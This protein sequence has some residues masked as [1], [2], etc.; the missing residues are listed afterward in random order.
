MYF[1][2]IATF[3][4]SVSFPVTPDEF[5]IGGYFA[6][7]DGGGGTFVWVPIP[8]PP[9]TII[10]PDEDLGIIFYHPSNP[11]GSQGYFKRIYSGPINVRW[12]GA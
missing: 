1:P 10:P 5:I 11:T 6:P 12:F 2:D 9:P 3:L 4:S 7:G 8:P